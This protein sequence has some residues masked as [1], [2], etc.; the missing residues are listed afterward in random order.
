MLVFSY[1]SSLFSFTC[2]VLNIFFRQGELN[3]VKSFKSIKFSS[4]DLFYLFFYIENI[5]QCAENTVQC[6]ENIVQCAENIVQCAENIVQCLFTL[7]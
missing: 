1:L 5:V 6:A 2:I 7:V 3:D 4:Q